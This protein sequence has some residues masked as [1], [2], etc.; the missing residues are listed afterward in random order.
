MSHKPDS[1]FLTR[2]SFLKG[3]A[4]VSVGGA[5]LLKVGIRGA[6]AQTAAAGGGKPILY[7]V[8]T[9]H[10]DTQW[11]WTV[12]DT[13]REW[14]PNTFRPNWEL[15]RKYPDYNFNYEAS[16]HYQWFKEYHPEDWKELQDWVAKGRWKLSGSWVNAVDVVVPSAESLFRQALYGQA[17]FR[18]EFGKVSRDIYL[19][20]CFGFPYSLPSIARHSGLDAF[21]TQKFDLWGGG[22]PA[23]F[24]VGR[25]EGVDGSQVVASL[26]PKAYN[27]QIHTDVSKDP[28]WTN[29]FTDAGGVR[30]NMRYFGTGD[31]GG[32]PG[33]E[34]VSWAQKSIEDKDGIARVVNTSADQ[35]AKDL[36]PAEIAALPVYKGELIM[37]NHGT[38]CYSSQA[39][40]K[41]WNR[42]NEQ[43]ADAAERAALAG[44]W[45]GG[46]PYPHQVFNEAWLRVL[47]HQFHDD[48]TG[49]CIP[50]AYTFSWNDELLSLGQFAG[51]LTTSVSAIARSLDTRAQG[52][53]LAVYNS[54]DHARRDCVEA[55]V[56]LPRDAPHVSVFDLATGKEVPSQTLSKTG[57][58]VKVAFVASAPSVGVQMYDVRPSQVPS[59]VASE[60]LTTVSA[61]EGTL[62]NAR[63]RVRV[64]ADGDLI[65]V[66]DK[67]A[68]RELLAQ[69]ATLE[70]F[71]DVSHAWPAWE[72]LYDVIGKPPRGVIHD[73]V[74]MD[75]VEHGPARTSLEVRRT[76]GDTTWTQTLRLT[77]GGD[78]LQIDNDVDWR[79]AGTL[80]KATFPLSVSNPN[81][82]FDMG[83]G[84]IERPNADPK[85]HEVPAQSWADLTAV[86]GKVGLAILTATKYGFDKP[87][88]STLRLTLLRTPDSGGSWAHQQTNDIGHHYFSYGLAPHAGDWRQGGV[89]GRAARFNQPLHAF[90]TPSHNGSGRSFSL[91]SISTPH[92]AV[93]ALKQ[94]EDSDEW[95]IRLHELY[96]QSAKNVRIKFGSA[97]QGIREINAAE[98]S[99]GGFKATNGELIADF[100]PYQPRTFALRLAPLVTAKKIAAPRSQSVKLPFNLNGASMHSDLRAHNFDGRGQTFAGELWPTQLERDGV[101]FELGKAGSLNFVE[102][103]GQA[104]TL[105]KGDFSRVVVL[106]TS[107]NGDQRGDFRVRAGKVTTTTP[108]R[109]ADWTQHIGQWDSRLSNPSQGTGG[110]QIVK[111]VADGKVQKLDRLKPAYLK[112]DRVA[113]VGTHR[114]TPTGDAL[115][116]F[117]YLFQYE[118]ALPKGAT[119]LVLPNNPNIRVAAVSVAQNLL[120]DTHAAGYL[121]EPQLTDA[122]IPAIPPR[123]P[124]NTRVFGPT[125]LQTF[126]GTNTSVQEEQLQ[127]PTGET[128]SW[129]IN[130]FVRTDAAPDTLTLIGG[131]GDAHDQTGAERYLGRVNGGIHFWGGS[132]DIDSGVPFDIGKWQMLT[133][134]YDGKTVI[135]YKNGEPIKSAPASLSE[136]SPEVHLAPRDTWGNKQHFFSGQ[137]QG[138]SVWNAALAPGAVKAL[139]TALP[140]G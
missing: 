134:T 136:A 88:D 81:A 129:T 26:R 128:E 15:M 76:L 22:R 98:E 102:C 97:I 94:A 99:V 70:Q 96:G 34:S 28:K 112:R 31:K 132:V 74:R 45:L 91:L 127:L 48:L 95:V 46:A 17:F 130:M 49:T 4:V 120:S 104:I 66:F 29:D 75:V 41:K 62:E 67:A 30:V 11:N 68:N 89:Q 6:L 56:T 109:V 8:A 106:A 33:E 83:L 101:H 110:G 36:T 59:G 139:M 55:T 25:W 125:A 27:T 16:I 54:L 18:R 24:S 57:R 43:L 51:A 60:L 23:P 126:D 105:P 107:I 58:Q 39:S 138:F 63:L 82:T 10:N 121:I 131:F 124:A 3:A 12:Q 85:R 80:V 114:H 44:Q 21:S 72:V 117:S 35:I 65:S 133:A 64:N 78:W 53:A 50:Q 20:D 71:H 9:A 61:T 19:P 84:T 111:D 77:E 14:I 116:L 93:R 73:N 47:W 37:T 13:L 113:W 137:V 52:V 79:S 123:P 69:P 100:G 92:V 140:K 42:T 1:E 5:S 122:T 38:G 103:R 135:V 108:L 118:I 7:L 32:T 40:M 115:Y 119:V 87:D 86:N 2:R 90:V